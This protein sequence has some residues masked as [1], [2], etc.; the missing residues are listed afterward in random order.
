MSNRSPAESAMLQAFLLRLVI[1]A[2]LAAVVGLG[3]GTVSA[4]VGAACIDAVTR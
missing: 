1:A 4:D 3:L 2:G